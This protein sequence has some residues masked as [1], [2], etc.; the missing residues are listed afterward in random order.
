[1]DFDFAAMA[2]RARAQVSAPDVPMN[3][4]VARSRDARSRGRVRAIVLSGALSLATIGTAA[5][6]G[7][8]IYEGVRLWI[9]GNRAAVVI[10]SFAMVNDPTANDLRSAVAHATFPV[11]LPIGLPAGTRIVRIWYAP[12][13]RPNILGLDYQDAQTKLRSGIALFDSSAI[14][15]RDTVLP[16]GSL[17]PPFQ[18]SY[19]WQLG[20]ET[21]LVLKRT[22]SLPDVERIKAATMTVGPTASLAVTE[23]MLSKA[24]ILG[25]AP[26]LPQ[27]AAR[28]AS[29]SGHS[30]VV[31]PQM[32]RSIPDLAKRGDPMLDTRTVYFSN[33]PSLH[34]EPDYSRATLRWPRVIAISAAGVRAIDAVFRSTGAG[35]NCNC[36]VLFNESN[37]K[38]DRV[39]E[40][41]EF[42]VTALKK[43]SIDTRTLAVTRLEGAQP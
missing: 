4:I 42:S 19:H 32:L 3:L 27:I 9:S 23:R 24:T 30:V 39:W 37:A 31:G 5:A 33:I 14:N 7:T 15:S 20:R 1:M 35:N 13:A 34:G 25:L 10:N 12:A 41:S 36:A 22:I 17:R 21:V 16:T 29:S 28:Y 38:T 6:F 2:K 8:S 26:S 11:V 43:Y 18:E 40:I